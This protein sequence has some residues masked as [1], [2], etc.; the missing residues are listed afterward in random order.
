M[1]A[2][3]GRRRGFTLIELLVVIAILAMLISLLLPAVQRAREAARRTQCRNNLKQLGIALHSYHE[4]HRTFPPA[5]VFS[6]W[7]SV[8]FHNSEDKAAYGW[9]A[10][11]LPFQE[12]MNL[13]KTLDVNGTE[14]HVL[15]QLPRSDN[16]L[17]MVLP[18]MLCPS[19]PSD[20]LNAL[21]SFKNDIY[22]RTDVATANYVAVEGLI[23]RRSQDWLGSRLD[24]YGILWPSSRVR[25][26]DV[27]DGTSN[28]LLIGERCWLDK[29]AVWIGTRN[30]SGNWDFGLRQI[31]G[32]TESKINQGGA[33]GTGGFSSRHV[34]GAHFLFADGHVKLLSDYIDYNQSSDATAASGPS[35][36]ELGLY[37]RLARRNDGQPVSEF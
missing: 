33:A 29:A 15:L 31:L 18:G 20:P 1:H 35:L 21:R 5:C 6:G 26:A 17:Q 14:L 34:G 19:D 13:F 11:L 10:F 2:P 24:P 28:T 37:Q 25:V 30:Y 23:M 32:T 8:P 36:Q 3:H 27:T 22:L 4:Q 12:Q 9:A 7:D 16:L